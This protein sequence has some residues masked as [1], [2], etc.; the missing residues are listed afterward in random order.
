MLRQNKIHRTPI[1]NQLT[2]FF[3]QQLIFKPSLACLHKYRVNSQ[4]RETS[5]AGFSYITAQKTKKKL[6][7][8]NACTLTEM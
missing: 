8:E 4:E 7:L 2:R 1:P 5:V 3:R 6:V